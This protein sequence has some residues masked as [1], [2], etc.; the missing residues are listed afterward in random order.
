[1]KTGTCY[2]PS[3]GAAMRYYRPY[4]ETYGTTQARTAATRAMIDQKLNE[5]EIHIGKPELKPGE[6]LSIEDNRYHITEAA[7]TRPAIAARDSGIYT[8]ADAPGY[9][10]GPMGKGKPKAARIYSVVSVAADG[11]AECQSWD[12]YGVLHTDR[13]AISTL[14]PFTKKS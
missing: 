12:C 6:R 2:F 11:T 5:R 8:A 13:L 14:V 10:R 4:C 1:M 3:Y 7:P 9:E